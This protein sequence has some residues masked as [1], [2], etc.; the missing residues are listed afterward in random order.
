MDEGGY[1]LV[2]DDLDDASYNVLTAVK[3]NRLFGV[4]PYNWYTAN[5]GTVLADAYYIGSVLYP[6]EFSDIDPVEKADEIYRQLVG[7]GVYSE[8]AGM[9]SGFTTISV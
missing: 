7:R 5:Y 6:D 1:S 2:L 4:L 9:Y 8:M 3:D